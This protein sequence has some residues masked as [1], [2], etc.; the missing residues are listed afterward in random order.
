MTKGSTVEEKAYF[1]VSTGNRQ[2]PKQIETF[3]T[4]VRFLTE[5]VYYE[6][7]IGSLLLSDRGTSSVYLIRPTS[8]GPCPGEVLH[9]RFYL[10]FT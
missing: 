7:F 5:K 4:K 2:D 1:T 8:R 3:I 9:P 6:S 10:R